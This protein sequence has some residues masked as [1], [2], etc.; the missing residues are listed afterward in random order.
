MANM[1]YMCIQLVA[2]FAELVGWFTC[3]QAWLAFALVAFCHRGSSYF[4]NTGLWSMYKRIHRGTSRLFY[5]PICCIWLSIKCVWYIKCVQSMISA[6]IY[7]LP[8]T[9]SCWFQ[10]FLVKDA[11]VQAVAYLRPVKKLICICN[12]VSSIFCWRCSVL[13]VNTHYIS[14]F[15]LVQFINS[16][17]WKSLLLCC[18]YQL[19]KLQVKPASKSEAASQS[20]VAITTQEVSAKDAESKQ[21]PAVVGEAAA[22]DGADK[23]GSKEMNLFGIW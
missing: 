19:V 13:S 21:E 7:D 10:T 16:C 12:L 4:V 3:M 8:F 18:K 9:F 23:E 15:W 2:Q 6:Y 14:G 17:L 11:M 20:A 22:V 1:L 5:Y